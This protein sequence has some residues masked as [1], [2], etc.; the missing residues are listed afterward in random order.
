MI[1]PWGETKVGNVAMANG[2]RAI[3]LLGD[4]GE[5]AIKPWSISKITFENGMFVHESQ[6]TFFEHHGAEKALTL[7]QGL[8]WEGGEVF[9]DYS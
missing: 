5:G 3:Y 8:P 4:H 2:E 7:A 6:G 9:D 1:S